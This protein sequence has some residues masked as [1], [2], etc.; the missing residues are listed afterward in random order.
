M[1][2]FRQVLALEPGNR[3]A[4][5]ELARIEALGGAGSSEDGGLGGSVQATF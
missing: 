4:Q 5:E 1:K 3:Q 2:D